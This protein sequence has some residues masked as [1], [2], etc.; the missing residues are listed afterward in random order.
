MKQPK[1]KKRKKRSTLFRAKRH[2]SEIEE[3]EVP[4]LTQ[5]LVKAV[6]EDT[7][8]PTTKTAKLI[9]RLLTEFFKRDGFNTKTARRLS[10]DLLEQE[11]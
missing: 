8:R 11:Q 2:R 9:G 5:M 6:R 1:R 4:A 10:R 3:L 7:A